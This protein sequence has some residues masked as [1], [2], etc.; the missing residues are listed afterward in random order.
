MSIEAA[1]PPAVPFVDLDPMHD[2]IR[3]E[4][5][6]AIAGVVARGDFILGADLGRFEEDFAAY[7]GVKHAVGVGSGT[8]AL[9]IATL[10]LGVEPGAEIVVPAHTYIASAL[11]P[12]HAGAVPVFC[13]VDP[14]TG[15][16]DAAAAAAA[17]TDR[18]AAILAVHLYGQVC[19]PG[20]LRE[21]AASQGIALIEDAAQAH[22]ASFAGDRA[23]SI[24]DVAA[25]SFYP[26]KNLGAFGDGGCIT[27]DDD[28]VA[29]LARRYRNLG[30][31]GKGDHDVPGMNE[32]LDTLQAAV[33]RAKLPR[34]DSWNE[35]RREA[36]AFY[37]AT[38][39][40]SIPML[41]E[42]EGA[43]DVFHLFPVLVEDRGEVR[44]MLAEAGIGTGIHYAPAVHEQPPFTSAA[45]GEFPHAE[46]WGTEEL[47]LP[48]FP[49]LDAEAVQRV[50]AALA[51]ATGAAS[52]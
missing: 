22:G 6:A 36:A 20:P 2:E 17:I 10:A 51:D 44:A 45:P 8:A 37:R 16:I 9:Q 15:L 19:D 18:T 43:S 4:I 52:R 49:G 24:G 42:R 31:L 14:R 32:R 47:S 38:L 3:D 23:G 13:D 46:R 5:D 50:A 21:L 34:L 7:C 40:A 48:M 25:F 1:K 11:G 30:Q 27:T 33:L 28:A 29:D 35:A 12:L 26:S 41:P 39:P